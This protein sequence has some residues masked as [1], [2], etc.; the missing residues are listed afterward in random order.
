MPI[1]H[2]S[3]HLKLDKQDVS[4]RRCYLHM[5]AQHDC[6]DAVLLH[7]IHMCG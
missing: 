5:H 7:S 3:I 1:L 6:L 4:M 2:V